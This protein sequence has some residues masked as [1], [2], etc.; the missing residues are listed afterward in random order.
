MGERMSALGEAEPGYLGRES[1][2]APDGQDLTVIYYSDLES[3]QRWKSHPE[4]LEAQD[5]G[6]RRWYSAYRVEI[7]RVERTYSFRKDSAQ[8]T[9]VVR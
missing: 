4:H 3:I 7:A 1:I 2:T 9:C 5:L 8:E 6:R